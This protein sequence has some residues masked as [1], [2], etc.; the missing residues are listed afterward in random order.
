MGDSEGKDNLGPRGPQLPSNTTRSDPHLT[1]FWHTPLLV[2]SPLTLAF[3]AMCLS[4]LLD[5]NPRR[6]RTFQICAAW[7]FQLLARC[8]AE[9]K[10]QF[11]KQRK[12]RQGVQEGGNSFLEAQK[13]LHSEIIYI[14]PSMAKGEKNVDGYLSSPCNC[15]I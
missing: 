14:F 13:D 3:L 7:Y 4:C 12:K 5:C 2:S 15:L 11:G 10:C 8:L 1:I 6:A 9:S